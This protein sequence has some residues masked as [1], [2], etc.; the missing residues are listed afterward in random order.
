MLGIRLRRGLAAGALAGILAGLVGL[1]VGA[2]TVDAAEELEHAAG[3]TEEAGGAHHDQATDASADPTAT[4]AFLADRRQARWGLMGGLLIVGVAL[5]ALLAVASGPASRWLTGDAWAR[6]WKLGAAVTFAVVILPAVLYPP[7]PPGAGSEGTIGVRSGV[8]FATVLLG[9]A[10]TLVAA[11]VNRRLARAGLT[12]PAR[13][14]ATGLLVVAAVAA[15]A[16]AM[17]SA[18]SVAATAGDM[19]AEL[20]WRF[21]L[22]S[23]A[24]QLALWLGVTGIFGLLAAQ[25]EGGLR[26]APASVT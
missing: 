8:Y 21:R 3:H 1:A 22:G 25:A 23:L 13:Q 20:V 16:L 11:G 15:I 2:P 5:G 17:P 10:T 26:R 19:P 14:T 24:T 12:R 9:L 6:A 4:A 7:V 18:G